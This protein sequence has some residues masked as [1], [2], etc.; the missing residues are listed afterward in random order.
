MPLSI[1]IRRRVAIIN[2]DAHFDLRPVEGR[3]NSGKLSTKFLSE[4]EE[5]DEHVDYFAIEFS[6]NR[7]QRSLFEIAKKEMKWSCSHLIA[8]RR[9]WR[10]KR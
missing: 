6:S 9:A 7:I 1:L 8:N 5:M 10:W 2:F 3:G 4:F